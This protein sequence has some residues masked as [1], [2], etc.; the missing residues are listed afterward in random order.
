M[1]VVA[2]ADIG[3]H[4]G[5]DPSSS[6]C[7]RDCTPVQCMLAIL[8]GHQLHKGRCV[9]AETRCNCK[10]GIKLEANLL[11]RALG[12]CIQRMWAA[13]GLC[14]LQRGSC[15]VPNMQSGF[16]PIMAVDRVGADVAWRACRAGARQ[17]HEVLPT[18]RGDGKGA[19]QC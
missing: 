7:P 14:E 4:G 10:P 18:L 15:V 3:A 5:D 16:V 2:D 12:G 13:Q 9:I 8:Q 11:W 19:Q 17:A 6:V 1:W